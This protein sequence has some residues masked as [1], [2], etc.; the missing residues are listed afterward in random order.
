MM[1]V[2][3]RIISEGKPKTDR[4]FL[5]SEEANSQ[6]ETEKESKG[7]DSLLVMGALLPTRFLFL[8]SKINGK[9]EGGNS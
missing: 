7:K 6:K 1:N 8:V 9:W 5:P 3:K 2:R 4:K